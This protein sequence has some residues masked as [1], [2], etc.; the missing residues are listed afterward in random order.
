LLEIN[1]E[2][3]IHDGSHNEL[4]QIHILLLLAIKCS[5]NR[6]AVGLESAHVLDRLA[7]KRWRKM[8]HDCFSR[9]LRLISSERFVPID[10]ITFDN[11]TQT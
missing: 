1:F 8:T 9:S 7:L 6:G 4:F 11:T 10:P 5:S 3:E 2:N